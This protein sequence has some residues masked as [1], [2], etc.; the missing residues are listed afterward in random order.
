L[1]D[2]S[3]IVPDSPGERISPIRWNW[4]K[5]LLPIWSTNQRSIQTRSGIQRQTWQ[6]IQP[7]DRNEHA[8]FYFY[9]PLEEGQSTGIQ[10][11]VTRATQSIFE[12]LFGW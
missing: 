5:L 12:Y 9:S 10:D 4:R 8:P 2:L 6:T 7:T 3:L 1:D 11:L